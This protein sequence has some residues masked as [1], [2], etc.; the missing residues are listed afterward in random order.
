MSDNCLAEHLGRFVEL[1][2]AEI[3][4]L[5]SVEVATRTC[6]RGGVVRSERDPAGEL[7]VVRRGWVF[8]ALLLEDGRRQIV[9][10]HFRGDLLGTDTLAYGT[11]PDTTVAL[12]EAELGVVD[13][14][15]LGRVFADHPRLG[16][17]LFALQQVDRVMLTDRLVSLGRASAKGRVAA[18]LLWI[19]GRLRLGDPA[20]TDTFP[21]PMTQEEIGD[22]TGLTAVHVNRTLRVLSETGLIARMPGAI[23]ILDQARL[24][25]LAHH[26]PRPERFDTAW[27]PPAR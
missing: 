22:A 14:A 25:R 18:L 11:A 10:L 8:C 26:I 3:A 13:K 12:T 4:A 2:A 9:Q 16:A 17:L 15:A 24:A 20:V 7:L 1:T 6:R 19:A 21:L 5:A 23:R 27:L